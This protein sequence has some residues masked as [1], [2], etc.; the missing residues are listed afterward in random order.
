ML[1]TP[2]RIETEDKP[3]DK[4]DNQPEPSIN[5]KRKLQDSSTELIL[6]QSC[7]MNFV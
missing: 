2:P 7:F 4:Q 1:N 6:S 3:S 5:K